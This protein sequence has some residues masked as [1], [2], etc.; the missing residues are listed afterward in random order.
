[1]EKG[2]LESFTDAVIAIVMTILILGIGIPKG[3][4]LHDLWQLKEHFVA[5]ILTF[6]LLGVTWHNHHH[7]FQISEKINGRVLWMNTFMLFGMSFLPFATNW[8]GANLA[9]FVPELFYGIAFL[10]FNIG[11]ALV[12]WAIIDANGE[13]SCVYEALKGDKKIIF[14][15][16]INIIAIL[17][18]FIYPPLTIVGCFMVTLIWVRP[19]KRVED[20]LK[21]YEDCEECKIKENKNK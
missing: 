2:R 18:V 9:A 10:I 1:M 19:N 14:S 16:I 6:F 4:T 13:D 3:N 11:Y 20:L 17:L 5:Y 8:V 7:M 15:L 12:A 21:N